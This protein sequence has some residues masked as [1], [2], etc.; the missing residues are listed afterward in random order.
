MDI[1]EY[2]D[3]QKLVG[4]VVLRFANLEAM[5]DALIRIQYVP[6]VRICV[7]TCHARGP[8][9][10]A[11]RTRTVRAQYRRRPCSR[12]V[13]PAHLILHQT[14]RVGQGTICYSSILAAVRVLC[15]SRCAGVS[16]R[17]Q[18]EPGHVRVSVPLGPCGDRGPRRRQIDNQTLEAR[19]EL[20]L[21]GKTLRGKGGAYP[22]GAGVE[23][24]D[25]SLV[26]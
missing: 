21:Q 16:H 3:K 1:N 11:A 14:C 12:T 22:R 24:R 18:H 19:Q 17:P 25:G 7:G 2:E 26:D 9:G 23:Y 5:A 6:D 10:D 8:C 15:A 4:A 13:A 20:R